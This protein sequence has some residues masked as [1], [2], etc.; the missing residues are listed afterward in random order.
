MQNAHLRLARLDYQRN[1]SKTATSTS[2][3]VSHYMGEGEQAHLLSFFGNDAEV[4]AVSAAIQENHRFQ[5]VYPDGTTQRIGF[6]SDPACYK[7]ALGVPG[8]K[9]SLRHV[10]AV[11]S[12]LHANGS[13]G[14]SFILNDEPHTHPLVW[15]TLATLLGLPVVPAWGTHMLEALRR[16]KKIIP[17][18]GVACAPAVVQIT[19]TEMLEWIGRECAAGHLSFPE[20][21]GPI[22]WPSFEP[23][24]ALA[25]AS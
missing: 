3:H 11:S 12:V 14:R 15:A 7:G 16:E 18:S 19:R 21:N 9:R 1:T 2:V 6:G 4:A 8:E 25:L 17:I 20:T 22:S 23:Q 13:A 24:E 5:L 10:I